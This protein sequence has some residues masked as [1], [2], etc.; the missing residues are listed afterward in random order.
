MKNSR[1][2]ALTNMIG[3]PPAIFELG[4]ILMALFVIIFLQA[5]SAALLSPELNLPLIDLPQG[6]GVGVT[7]KDMMTFTLTENQTRELEIFNK[8]RKIDMAEFIG[9]IKTEKPIEI[10]LRIDGEVRQKHTMKVMLEAQANGV[11]RISQ[12]YER[13]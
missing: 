2:K 12:A 9:V 10:C 8:Q 11:K 1:I 3:L 13:E 4:F 7:S 5:W 6:A